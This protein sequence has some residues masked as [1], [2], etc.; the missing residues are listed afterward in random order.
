MRTSG[1][2]DV[3]IYCRDL[4]CTVTAGPTMFACPMRKTNLHRLLARRVDGIH[5][6]RFEQGEIGPDLFATPA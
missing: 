1:V 2:R 5:L 6:A 3:L 4:R